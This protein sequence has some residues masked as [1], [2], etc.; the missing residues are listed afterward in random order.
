MAFYC[1]PNG[2]YYINSTEGKANIFE[3]HY[4]L[5]A[6]GYSLSAQCGVIGNCYG[7]SGLNPWRWQSDTVNYSAGYGLFQFTPARGY[8]GPM[9]HVGGYGPN[10]STTAVV[11]G[12]VTDGDAQLDC[13][14]NDLLGKWVGTCWRSYWDSTTYPALYQRRARILAN[15]GSGSYLSQNQYKNIDNIP[16]AVFAFLACYEGPAVPDFQN[17]VDYANAVYTILTG[18]PPPRPP[19]PTRLPIW[20]LFK[21]K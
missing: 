20:L 2:Y 9:S 18:D 6:A 10:L 15:Y 16:D 5:E 1:K 17:R 7:E 19:D 3:M 12:R 4:I 21:F 13:L 11:G 14:V 8:I